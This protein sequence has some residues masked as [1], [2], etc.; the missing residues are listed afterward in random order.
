MYTRARSIYTPCV[1]VFVYVLTVRYYFAPRPHPREEAK[2]LSFLASLA[3]RGNPQRVNAPARD[4]CRRVC[5]H[6]VTRA[7][8]RARLFSR[9]VIF[10]L[11]RLPTL[12]CVCL[13]SSSPSGSPHLIFSRRSLFSMQRR[14]GVRSVR[15]NASIE[16]HVYI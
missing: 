3:R 11:P 5:T 12:L 7:R 4:E 1:R 10:C 2:S 8:A 15:R 9:V 13:L 14:S 6:A 16:L